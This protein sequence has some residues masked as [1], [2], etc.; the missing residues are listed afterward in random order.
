MQVAKKFT[1]AEFVATPVSAEFSILE[2]EDRLE[3]TEICDTNCKCEPAPKPA[4]TSG[5]DAL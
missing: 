4:A 3:F 1:E 2:L 5:D